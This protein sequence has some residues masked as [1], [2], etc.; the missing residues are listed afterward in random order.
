MSSVTS[1]SL[2]TEDAPGEDVVFIID[3][4]T[5]AER[6]KEARQAAQLTQQQLADACGISMQAVSHWEQGRSKE[7]TASNLFH[8][9]DVLRVDPRWLATG[10]GPPNKIQTVYSQV[11]TDLEELPAEKQELVLSLVRSLAA[12]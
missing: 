7:I 5:L 4:V 1:S 2:E 10:E 3:G 9:A 11:V 6:I 12:K 8:L